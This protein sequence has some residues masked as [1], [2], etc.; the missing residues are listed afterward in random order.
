MDDGH[1][2]SA[3][4]SIV[5]E[6]VA[7]QSSGL[8]L[9][10]CA[11]SG[12]AYATAVAAAAGDGEAGGPATDGAEGDAGAAADPRASAGVVAMQVLL[13]GANSVHG[14]W[15]S[16]GPLGR[17]SHGPQIRS[18]HGPSLSLMTRTWH[19]KSRHRV[20]HHPN[21]AGMGERGQ[22]HLG[23]R[24]D[25][26]RGR[27]PSVLEWMIEEALGWGAHEIGQGS[28]GAGGEGQQAHEAAQVVK[29]KH[30]KVEGDE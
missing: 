3:A 30:A 19:G 25:E 12:Q 8:V 13:S 11:G 28:R 17:S 24:N 5:Q 4:A 27:L 29:K 15:P 18:R 10:G 21:A 2:F 22:G 23:R 26:G 1:K 16:L 9:Y 14:R 7:T 6:V 20:R